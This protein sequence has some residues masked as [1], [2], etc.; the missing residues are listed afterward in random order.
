MSQQF[1]A[2]FE[3]FPDVHALYSELQRE[4]YTVDQ[5]VLW[6]RSKRQALESITMSFRKDRE[7]IRIY[8]EFNLATKNFSEL[9]FESL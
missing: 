5:G 8:Q 4:G 1:D 6:R 9:L 7:V 3:S 2:I